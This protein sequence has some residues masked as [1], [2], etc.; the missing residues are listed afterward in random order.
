MKVTIDY[1][2]T[3]GAMTDKRG[4]LVG[5]WVG[6]EHFGDAEKKDIVRDLIKLKEAGFTADEIVAM[7]EG[8]LL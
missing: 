2:S 3:T 8:G 6:L 5:T 4:T 7:K 1:D